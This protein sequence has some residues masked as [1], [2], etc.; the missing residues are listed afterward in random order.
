MPEGTDMVLGK[1]KVSYF[2]NEGEEKEVS[3]YITRTK[4][5]K[6]RVMKDE[7][8]N[9]HVVEKKVLYLDFETRVV[10]KSRTD[11][12]DEPSSTPPVFDW[13][14]PYAPAPYQKRVM[15]TTL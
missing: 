8:G 7:E 5:K 1:R 10:G 11:G 12:E 4:V 9:E 13:N 3:T 2:P 15:D 6:Q 14:A